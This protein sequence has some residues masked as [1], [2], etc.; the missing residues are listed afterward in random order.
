MAAPCSTGG[1]CIPLEHSGMPSRGGPGPKRL[2]SL[3][4][5]NTVSPPF[6]TLLRYGSMV[7]CLF[8]CKV[9]LRG[10][11][12]SAS[13]RSKTCTKRATHF[14]ETPW[15]NATLIQA[16]CMSSRSTLPSS[17]W[18]GATPSSPASALTKLGLPASGKRLLLAG[19]KWSDASWTTRS[20][21]SFAS[22]QV[23]RLSSS[24]SAWPDLQALDASRDHAASSNARQRRCLCASAHSHTCSISPRIVT[25]SST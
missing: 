7:T 5:G 4:K 16:R 1:T 9:F 11:W 2:F 21:G 22:L 10:I 6:P 20:S 25:C 3:A 17:S 15:Q 24:S 12:Y 19:C 8:G 14:S 23:R 13:R 18:V